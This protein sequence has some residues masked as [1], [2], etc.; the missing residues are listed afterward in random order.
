MVVGEVFKSWMRVVVG[1]VIFNFFSVEGKWERV[2]LKE[3]F[4]GK[5]WKE[6]IRVYVWEGDCFVG[7]RSFY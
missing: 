6:V 5:L 1:G 3:G 2:E 4:R 7:Y